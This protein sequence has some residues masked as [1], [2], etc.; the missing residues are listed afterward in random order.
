MTIAST[1]E[2]TILGCHPF[3]K[4]EDGKLKSRIGT[5]FPKSRTLVT[6]KTIHAFQRRIYIDHVNQLRAAD[7][8]PP[9]NEDEEGQEWRNA[10]DLLFEEDERISIRPNPDN[11]PLAFEADELLAESGIAPKYRINFLYALDRRVRQAV[12][13]RGEYWRITALPTSPEQM[14]RMIVDSKLSIAGEKIYY[15]NKAT[16]TRWLT[17]QEFSQLG[18]LTPAELAAHLTEIQAHCQRTNPRG[19][20]EVDF[21][22]S[23]E[24]FSP[25]DFSSYDFSR[26][27]PDQLQ[28]AYA[29]LEERFREAVAPEFRHDDVQDIQ[30]RNRMFEA[31]L[32]RDDERVSEETLLG[33]SPE[34]FMQIHWLPGGRIQAGELIFDPVFSLRDLQPDNEELRELCDERARAFIFNYVRQ[35]ANLEY[36]N[37]GRVANSLSRRRDTEKRRGVYIAEVKRRG[38]ERE[39][40]SII[41]MQKWGVRE[42]L[43]DGKSLQDAMMRSDEYTEYLLDRR[44]GCWQLGMNL[45]SC[46]TARKICER[47]SSSDP[48]TRHLSGVIIWSPYIERDYI[49]GI[50]TDKI[51]RHRLED[52]AFALRLAALLGDAAAVNIIVGRCDRHGKVLFD[53]GDEV[54][55]ES[56]PGSPSEIVVADPTGTFSNFDQSLQ[57]MA[58]AYAEPVNRRKPFVPEPAAF[59][60]TYLQ[61]FQTS[62]EQIRAQYLD[63]RRAFDTLFNYRRWDPNGSFEYRWERVLTRLERTD[64]AELT[65][66]IRRH[67]AA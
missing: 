17:Y 63:L 23:A 8:R 56:P 49:R 25:Q 19:F 36:V 33:L 1:S 3:A 65:S 41:R 51:P 42:H 50:A 31:L 9:L 13:R 47:Y 22:I 39:I 7:G 66:L 27:D 61:A 55:V 60:E 4:G 43:D 16:G 54:V 18:Q 67:I 15:Y 14:A 11:M 32:V 35:Y 64:P 12:Q 40:V 21:F 26:L 53:D 46:V 45:P 6:V 29:S 30:W 34:F 48:R 58:P 57:R 5:I 59:A 44:L 28:Q 24:S 38:E 62:F 37:I 52:P 2:L 20:P 10:V